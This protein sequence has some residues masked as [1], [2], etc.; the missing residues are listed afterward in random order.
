MTGVLGE[1]KIFVCAGL[2][3]YKIPVLVVFPNSEVLGVFSHSTDFGAAWQV[4]GQVP[5]QVPEE[6]PE[7][8]PIKRCSASASISP[9]YGTT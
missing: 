6:L 7:Q 2:G 4:P 8:A 9:R 3:K 5:E 1:C